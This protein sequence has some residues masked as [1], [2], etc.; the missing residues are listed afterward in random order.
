MTAFP[1]T[2]PNR[3]PVTAL[4]GFIGTGKTTLLNQILRNREDKKIAVI[5]N[6]MSEVNIAAALVRSGDASLS[7]AEEKMVEMSNGCICRTL[8]KDL[9]LEMSART[10]QD[11][12]CFVSLKP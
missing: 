2:L 1:Q 12:R 8:R 10:I 11:V 7:H 5:V 3:L 9:L 4:S 6:D